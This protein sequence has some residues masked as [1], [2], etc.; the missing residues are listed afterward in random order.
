VKAIIKR[1]I[2]WPLRQPAGNG[3]WLKPGLALLLGLWAGLAAAQPANDNFT[4]AIAIGG[5]TGSVS[6]TNNGASLELPCEATNIFFDDFSA[7]TN[8]VWY[9]WTAPAA[10]TVTFNTVGSGFDTVLAVYQPITLTAALCSAV[11]IV[12]D[13]HYVN[14]SGVVQTNSQV[15][16][17]VAAGGT[18]YV[19]VNGNA[20]ADPTN[21]AGT[22]V[23]NWSLATIASGTFQFTTSVYPVS[24]SDSTAP[25]TAYDGT[26][27]NAS[28]LGGRVTVT[29]TGGASG[30]VA[31]KYL[32]SALTYTN[33]Y[34]TNYYGTNVL[35][36]FIDTNN[37][38]FYTNAY[39]TNIVWVHNYGYYDYAYQNYVVTNA[40][41]NAAFL[42]LGMVYSNSFTSGPGVLTAVPT[43]LPFITNYTVAI[44]TPLSSAVTNVFGYVTSVTIRNQT[45]TNG[46]TYTVGAV[47]YTNL[48][49]VYKN[50][51]LTN[52]FGTNIYTAFYAGGGLL[53]TNY[54]FTNWV[55]GFSYST[56]SIYTNGSLHQS[57]SVS[58]TTNGYASSGLTNLAESILN[59][60]TAQ[61]IFAGT[62][63][64]TPIPTNIPTMSV[65]GPSIM[66]TDS[67]GDM[68][69]TT[70]NTFA[71]IVTATQIVTS[72]SGI[73]TN[74]G[75][76]TFNDYQ[77][78]ADILVPV[79][80]AFGPD[81][82]E[83]PFIPS[84]AQVTLTGAQLDPLESPDLQ[85]PLLGG[86][87]LINALSPQFPP[88][89][90]IL[91]L[92]RSTFRVDK[93]VNGGNATVSVY[94]FGTNAAASV[95]VDYAI[96]P[97]SPFTPPGNPTDSAI[98]NQNN[99]ANQFPLQA[100][101][102]YALPNSDY[103]PVTGT[104]SW[105]AKDYNPK[106]I[107]I[108]IIDNGL[109]ENNVDMLIQLHNALPQPTTT[110]Y[111][112]TIGEV[113]AADLTI[114]FNDKDGLQQPAGAVD[115]IWN[116]DKREDSSPP[117]LNYPG[118]QGD[119]YAV[120]EQTDGK[121][122]VAG[123]FTSFDSNPYNR[124]VRLL[125][126]G[127]QDTTFL[128]APNSGANNF[129]AALAV[130]PDGKILI[131]GKFTAFNG[132]SLPHI[133]RI[134][135]NGLVDPT[136]NPG[137]G[138]AGT[139]A[140]VWAM[141]LQTNGQIVIAGDFSSYNGT[142][143]SSVARLN[144]DG[145]LDTS[146]NP[147]T[148]PD[149]TVN[150]VAV[151]SIGRVILGGDFDEVAGTT[152]GGVARLNV[153]GSVDASFI[154]GVGTY[155]PT[156][157]FTDP[158]YALALQPDGQILVG[159]GFSYVDYTSYNGIVRLNSLD[160]TVDTSFNPGNGTFNPATQLADRVFAITL[161][162]DGNILIG[163]DFSTFNQ[164]RRVGV[165]R[166][167]SYGA[168]D[169]SF[170]DTA[171]NQFAGLINDYHNPNAINPNIYPTVN[172][173]NFVYS[174]AVEPVTTNVLI[175]GGFLQVGGGYTRDD[176]HPR[177]NV[178]RLIGGGT[179]GPGNLQFVGS[180]YTANKDDGTLFITLTRTNGSLGPISATIANST[181]GSGPGVAT[182]ND[183][184]VL[185]PNPLWPE[186]YALNVN[187]SWM[188]SPAFYGPNNLTI[189]NN[190][191]DGDPYV[192]L[193]I[194]NNTNITGNLN[195]NLTLSKP[196][197]STYLLGGEAIALN[198][199]LGQGATSVPLT[200]IDDNRMH[201]VLS[202][203][204]A[205]YSVNENV[206]TATITVVRNNGSDGL[207]QVSFASADG[208]ATN[209]IDYNTVTNTLTFLAGVTSQTFTVPI[210][211]GTA[212]RP[213]RFLNLTLFNVTGGATLGVTNASLT[214][215]NGNFTSGHIS[216]T[217][218]TFGANENAGYAFVTL[219]RLGGSSGTISVTAITGDGSAVN[220]TNYLGST[221]VL[222]WN[223]TN[224][225]PQTIAIPVID[226]GVV[227]PNL[228]VNLRLTN[229]ILNSRFNANVLGLSQYTN[230]TL[231]IT[232]VDNYGGVQFSASA[233]SVK[234]YAGFAIIPV[235]RSGG[236]AQTVTVNYF[237][238]DGTAHSNVDYQA[239]S[240][241][242]TFPPG[243]VSTNFIVPILNT[244]LNTGLLTLGL[245]LSNATPATALGVISNATLNI[246]DTANLNET[247]GSPD[248][249][250]SS[251][252][253][254][255]GAV[256]ALALQ[257]DNKLVAGGD[258][259]A[260]DGVPRE[261]I[262]RLNSDGS[263][264]ATF[265][266][267]SSS[268]GANGDVRS[269]IVQTDGRLVVGG[270]FTNFNSV[271]YNRIARLNS[272]GSL[273]SLFNPGAG[274]DSPVYALGET[275]IGGV[276]KIV[277]GG[278]FASLSGNVFNYIGRLND[279]GTPDTTFNAG[280]LGANGTVFALALQSDGKVVI[281][282]DFT[283]YNNTPVNH[284]ARLNVD[285][286]LDLGFTN[287]ISNAAAGA[288]GSVRAIAVQ[289]D[290]KILIGGA[291][292]S[293]NGALFNRICRLNANGSTDAQFTPGV[294]ADSTVLSLALQTDER[295]VVG[296]QFTHF[297]GVS[298]NYIT[299]LNPDG[300]VD[301]TINFGFGANNYVQAAVIQESTFAGYPTNVPDEKIIIGGSFTQYF[302]EPHAYVARIYGG[303]IS[304][305]GAYEFSAANYQ[306][307]E[308]GFN[309]FITVIRTGG[310]SGTNLVP[311]ATSNG[312]AVAG[313]NYTT[314]VTNLNFTQGEVIQTVT[315][316][317][318]DDN[319]I[320]PDLTVDLAINP[321]QTNQ[322][323]NQPVAVLT[324]INDDSAISFSSPSY[325]VAK[326]VSGGVAQI[327]LFRLGSANGISTV[328]FNTTTNGTATPVTD[329]TPQTNILITFSPGV[330]NL[331]VPVPIINNG[332][333]E[334]N[335]TVV[336]QLTNAVGS[337]LYS[338]SNATLTINDTL[339]H[340]GFLYFGATNYTVGSSAGSAYLSVYRTNGSSGT[341]SVN[342][343]TVAGTAKPGLDYVT[344]SG[345]IYFGDTVTSNSI[346]IPILPNGQVQ[347]PVNLS[348][349][350]SN[351]SNGAQ[352]GS[353]T[354][355]TLTILS[356]ITGVS[357]V[358][359]TNYV[360]ESTNYGLVFVQRIG[361]PTNAFTVNYAT[362]DGS[363]IAGVN[364]TTTTGT[365]AFASGELLKT[366]SI[367]LINTFNVTNTFFSLSLSAPTPGVQL[368][369]PSNAV[370]IIQPSQ[371]GLSFTNAALSVSKN[372][373]QAV[374]T[375]VCSNPSIEPVASSN[376]VPLSVNYF[377]TDGTAIAGQDYTN[378]SGTLV[379][380]NGIGTNTFTVPIINS[381]I[382]TGNRTFSI[383]LTNA[384][385]PG[386]IVPPS[387][388]VVTIMDNNSGLSF[389]SPT[390][391]ILKSGVA[392]NITIIRTDNT[393]LTSTVNFATADGTAVAGTD[394]VATNGLMTFTN[395]ETSHTFSLRVIATTTVQPDKTVLLQLSNPTNGILVSPSAATLTIRDN[396]GSLVV[397]AGS[398]LLS[399]SLMQNGII[400]PN[401]TVKMLF[402]FRVSG[403]TN[404]ANL[405]A[406]LLPTNG[407]TS[408]TPSGPVS[409]GPLIARGPSASQAFTFT[410]NGTNGQ[411]I[412]ATFQLANGA[413]NLGQAAFTYTLGTWT[414]VLVST[415][416]IVINDN[417]TASPYPS[418]ITVSNLNGVI[419]K[420]TL[421]L[422]NFYHTYPKDVDVLVV[423]PAQQDTLVM[424]HTGGGNA[425]G[426][427]T[428]TFADSAT[429][430]L[431]PYAYPQTSITN[432][433]YEPTAY[434]P[435]PNFP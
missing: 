172:Y 122:I 76:L 417:T 152:S 366:I 401:E 248:S 93:D 78:S 211:N 402:A 2:G 363:A 66:T 275:F 39:S 62:G 364:Y 55:A 42:N 179:P 244:N 108:P 13:H 195:G 207:V 47:T 403:G 432:G 318:M 365:L 338:P 246:I 379:F 397:P 170:M 214:I 138:V 166:L 210:I 36:T 124:I 395:G 147:G 426:P 220:K 267:P 63:L 182:T 311:F 84:L 135:T 193:Q 145:S 253:G 433:T 106:T 373:G 125:S 342:Y 249:T 256:Y 360:S 375:V 59:A 98:V 41:T 129:I 34:V 231:I 192:Y 262:A 208:T 331:L 48:V 97:T 4:N 67:I 351:P 180:S 30:R 390:Y 202:F 381:G 429:N 337:A 317:V 190:L 413:V 85:P 99:P 336:L 17:S 252:A 156:S 419:I 102:D 21:D 291:F 278:A 171:Y 387:V 174:I 435:I 234:K 222:T 396:S 308:N 105:G 393:N 165:A 28:V 376:S 257:A 178:A 7:V 273:D 339:Q 325:Q 73:T 259:T 274:A 146:F 1:F 408:P 168:V 206:G 356:D 237:T 353:P 299:R 225:T 407:V 230:A 5:L 196:D 305:S 284:I 409:Y 282:G 18:Y 109:V 399:E 242:F 71:Q 90:E 217:A 121:A 128:A 289:P 68:I 228:T 346:V 183:F 223:N 340:Y 43:N 50:T 194:N 158:V 201:G 316:P 167:F 269:V 209:G 9:A 327:N 186:L 279:D 189:P 295:I 404:V 184:S 330:T 276:R 297:S 23:L 314:V 126:N 8:S 101:S 250:Y 319:V 293:V 414:N 12:G 188:V 14:A 434:L 157:G 16:F 104:L 240:G 44:N 38:V 386:K 54:Y 120:A 315:V 35:T 27:V 52:Y 19:S 266:Y 216:F 235:V 355:T 418:T 69:F 123:N 411:N 45:Q 169:T 175:G 74:A 301:P 117:F 349:Q 199:A 100:G 391:S 110:S 247:P 388:Q 148:G 127:Y 141:A 162:P 79:N 378:T 213:D 160:G 374:I 290:G 46:S 406:T 385:S 430:S 361:V 164:T 368:A 31:V 277:V 51:L 151:D 95:S 25:N 86:T 232:N 131:G 49:N 412:A 15:S 410:A 224:S 26:T 405:T 394:Y 324:I 200:I 370:V 243:V 271:A 77:M 255:N 119:V 96:D 302:N 258:F 140:M 328:V 181:I 333:P 350:L 103:T 113:N 163:G 428:L 53:S 400:D 115:R 197:G 245:V 254:F 320:T 111:G 280:G 260:A 150:A 421:T 58:Y 384:T 307:D 56:N 263:F 264:D 130:Q 219:N 143:V 326:N 383:T 303:S 358:S 341:V 155:N 416:A 251:S 424:A 173:P 288:N 398:T 83:A 191:G 205:T 80:I 94:R 82:P 377:T 283:A 81:A 292:T 239:T 323:G 380:T 133:A 22:Y 139:N 92:E 198:P 218:P 344:S 321:A 415:N 287:A 20:A 312:T 382:V 367:P 60:V 159:G 372:V 348:V 309:A 70:T 310:T 61:S 40:S 286:S 233:Y 427:V 431:P 6:G 362:A 272:D 335:T 37:N 229:A 153:D 236:S 161:Q 185:E 420:A 422:T 238:V 132:A 10:G 136:F 72:A 261:R 118:V 29:R 212:V 116:K 87:A 354:N 285:G 298:R 215:I 88:G 423:S 112:A 3:R 154:L 227:T 300:T 313:V 281:G 64:L 75:T 296:G 134:D 142:N 357:F 425:V 144:A 114:L 89:P 294:G 322:I 33:V 221:N 149:A 334:G 332:L 32:V 268:L 392:T 389:S 11:Q 352:L 65:P 137:A 270:F 177:S 359:G 91:C 343:T 371:A 226:D 329:Y 57:I 176:I 187:W 203:S 347:P 241:Q 265:S 345:S 369:N 204:S 304:G 107:T 24:E 306:I